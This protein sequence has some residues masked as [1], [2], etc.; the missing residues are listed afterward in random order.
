MNNEKWI[1]K[2]S[3]ERV[4]FDPE[5][6]RNSLFKAGASPE[7]IA[8]I[9][10]KI[11][12]KL[13]TATTTKSIYK[14]AYALLRQA[15]QK[16]AGQYKLKTAMLEMGPSG[17]PFEHFV[18]KLLTH[19]GYQTEVGTHLKGSC[20]THEVDII[21]ERPDEIIIGECKYHSR[22]GYKSDVKIPLYV[23]ARFQDLSMGDEMKDSGKKINCAIISNTRFTSDAEAYAQCYDIQL[24]AWDYPDK[25]SLKQRIALSKHY[26]ITCIHALTKKDK[27]TLMHEG[28]VSCRQIFE[29]ESIL[30]RFDQ[31]KKNRVWSEIQAICQDE[32]EEGVNN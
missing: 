7:V 12:A 24:I 30:N 31:T 13:T 5:K 6:L 19:Q 14:Q 32:E 11:T 8:Q 4:V 23:H 29:E 27:E 15:S 1:K 17:Y 21:A 3:G 2:A 10:K 9:T 26:P 22:A 25:G 18:A 20:L 16:L 28:V